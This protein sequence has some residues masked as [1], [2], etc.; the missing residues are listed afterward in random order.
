MSSERLGSRY[1]LAPDGQ[2]KSRLPFRDLKTVGVHGWKAE[3]RIT[4]LHHDGRRYCF[5]ELY[6]LFNRAGLGDAAAGDNQRPPGLREHSG[7]FGQSLR[8]SRHTWY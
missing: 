3:K 8:I 7:G 2:L 4:R 1:G 6:K 5:G